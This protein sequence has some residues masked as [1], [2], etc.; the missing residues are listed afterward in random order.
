MRVSFD[1]LQNP[2]FLV[3]IPETPDANPSEGN[4]EG[5]QIGE[6]DE[7]LFPALDLLG[8]F[9]PEFGVINAEP[10]LAFMAEHGI[11][12]AGH[13]DFVTMINGEKIGGIREYFAPH[14]RLQS[15]QHSKGQ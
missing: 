15:F 12:F 3:R 6:L 11:P 14:D 4:E 10:P 8:F 2:A 1:E 7:F 13:N 9:N 5:F